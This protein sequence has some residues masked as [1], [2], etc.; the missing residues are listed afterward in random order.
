MGIDGPAGSW[1]E[2]LKQLLRL[3]GEQAIPVMSD[4]FGDRL[5]ADPSL[6]SLIGSTSRSGRSGGV[7]VRIVL[8]GSAIA[9]M[10][11]LTAGEAALRGRAGLKLV[12]LS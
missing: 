6:S 3:G 10:R 4:E 1:E 7:R 11:S 2:A 8:C 12:V 9:M 5:E